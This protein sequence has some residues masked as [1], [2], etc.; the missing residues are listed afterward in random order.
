M[1]APEEEPLPPMPIEKMKS[2]NVLVTDVIL[3]KLDARSGTSRSHKA[4]RI[5]AAI[6]AA[7]DDGVEAPFLEALSLSHRS[8]AKA[9][10]RIGLDEADWRKA[11]IWVPEAMHLRIESICFGEGL[12]VADFIRGAL[13]LAANEAR[14]L[15]PAE[16]DI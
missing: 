9:R 15:D 5:L 16:Q 3:S 14:L 8:T 6:I 13:I 10:R 4:R 7:L 1:I 2:V 12:R 11:I